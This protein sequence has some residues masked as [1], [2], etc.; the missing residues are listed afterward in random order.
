MHKKNHIIKKYWY[1]RS[2]QNVTALHCLQSYFQQYF[3]NKKPFRQTK[4]HE[5]PVPLHLHRLRPK[6]M[7][8][9]NLTI[10]TFWSQNKMCTFF[11]SEPKPWSCRSW[12]RW[13]L[14]TPEPELSKCGDFATLLSTV[15][16]QKK[17]FGRKKCIKYRY[18]NFCTGYN[19]KWCIRKNCRS[20]SR[21]LLGT[22]EP[23]LSK[24]DGSATLLS[25]VFKQ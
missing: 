1:Q 13:F 22:P 15:F 12:S 19:L 11:R 8:S 4:M 24:Y 3:D 9:E 2:C 23:E 10:L 7:H 16:W 6:M 21:W 5:I 25:T 17:L 14:G 18:R 20:C